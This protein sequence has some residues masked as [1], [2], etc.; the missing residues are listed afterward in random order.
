MLPLL[1]KI[2][3]CNIFLLLISLQNEGSLGDDTQGAIGTQSRTRFRLRLN[4][5]LDWCSYRNGAGTRNSCLRTRSCPRA[6]RE[7]SRPLRASQH[8]FL[9]DTEKPQASRAYL[10]GTVKLGPAPIT[11]QNRA[12]KLMRRMQKCSAASVR[13]V[14]LCCSRAHQKHEGWLCH[15]VMCPL[16]KQS[17]E[18]KMRREETAD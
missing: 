5:V 9:D 17:R 3:R 16:L 7:K 11:L 2:S 4:L 13:N 12:I 15:L 18:V 6:F 10:D 1:S 8:Y 14:A